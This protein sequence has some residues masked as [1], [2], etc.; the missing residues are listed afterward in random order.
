[1]KKSTEVIASLW[2]ATLNLNPNVPVF[3]WD[4]FLIDRTLISVGFAVA[5]QET[6]FV[7]SQALNILDLFDYHHHNVVR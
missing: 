2:I 4:N 5:E 1:M 7:A 6:I 3:R